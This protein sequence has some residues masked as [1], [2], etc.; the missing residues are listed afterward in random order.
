MKPN[1][2]KF[3]IQVFFNTFMTSTL[4]VGIFLFYSCSMN[5]YHN[6]ISRKQIQIYCN[7]YN[8]DG[9]LIRKLPGGFCYFNRDGSFIASQNNNNELVAYDSKM[10]KQ[11]SLK[12]HIHHQI[13]QNSQSQYLILTSDFEKYNGQLTRFD[14]FTILSKTGQIIAKYNFKD[15][16]ELIESNKQF[17]S[18][19]P[20]PFDWDTANIDQAEVEFSH[21]NSFYEVPLQ[22]KIA[23][24]IS[25][26]QGDY[27]S[28]NM[29]CGCIIFLD[30]NLK[31]IKTILK[32][33]DILTLHDAQVL[34]NGNLLLYINEFKSNTKFSGQSMIAEYDPV[35]NSLIPIFNSFNSPFSGGVQQIEDQYFFS[36]FTNQDPKATF[37]DKNGIKKK[38]IHFYG[39][40]N[41][42]G[43]QQAKALD[44]SSFLI[45]N[46]GF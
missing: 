30:K 32:I 41:K 38:E 10:L 34:K 15:H 44:L 13:N 26:E 18:H 22:I 21:S 14:V 31:K 29:L 28:S 43:F 17:I 37:I 1:R 35:H 7:I 9:E 40:K 8:Q 39:L 45:R 20:V 27:I 2:L 19:Q 23:H 24:N 33:P 25:I 5:S 4:F 12:K 11:W 16:P 36:D 46:E 6:G 3:S 42:N